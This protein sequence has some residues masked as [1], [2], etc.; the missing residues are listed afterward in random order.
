MKSISRKN[1]K[2]SFLNLIDRQKKKK[3]FTLSETKI[4][5]FQF[6]TGLP[7]RCPYTKLKEISI[8]E[9]QSFSIWLTG[10]LPQTPKFWTKSSNSLPCFPHH[11][12]K[13]ASYIQPNCTRLHLYINSANEVIFFCS[14]SRFQGRL[15][16]KYGTG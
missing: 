1:I 16:A 10:K 11:T 2:K 3:K 15:I 14:V 7:T 8:F 9:A 13:S 6:L 12:P 4:S 5:P